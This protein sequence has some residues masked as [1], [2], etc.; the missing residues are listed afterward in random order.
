MR[1]PRR[2]SADERAFVAWARTQ[3]ALCRKMN[4]HGFKGWPDQLVAKPG[5]GRVLW[6]EFKR[7][8]EDLDPVQRIVV[9]Q[10]RAAGQKVVVVRSLAEAQE[11]Y[12]RHR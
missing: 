4:G 9:G 5:V 7:E 8:G 11:A 10:L 12:R 2:E 6:V 1:P 3:G